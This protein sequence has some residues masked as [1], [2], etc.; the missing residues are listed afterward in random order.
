M[1]FMS[2]QSLSFCTVAQ[3]NTGYTI[4]HDDFTSSKLKAGCSVSILN[5]GGGGGGG[6]KRSVS[7]PGVTI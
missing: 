5:G 2:C 1:T 3:Q 4:L 6:R 7:H